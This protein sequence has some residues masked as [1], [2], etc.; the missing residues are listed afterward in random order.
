MI[1]VHLNVLL[2]IVTVKGEKRVR[3]NKEHCA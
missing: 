1:R 2:S 3:K